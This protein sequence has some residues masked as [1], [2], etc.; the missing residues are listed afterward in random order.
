MPVQ[1]ES[2]DVF[3]LLY[4]WAVW[5]LADTYFIKYTP[6]S[7]IVVIGVCALWYS[8]PWINRKLIDGNQTV[9]TGLSKVTMTESV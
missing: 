3:Q 1:P 4:W 9:K 5:T 2:A 8:W 6:F 7:E